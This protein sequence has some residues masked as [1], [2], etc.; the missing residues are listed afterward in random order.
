MLCIYIT[1]IKLGLNRKQAA[2]LIFPSVLQLFTLH[3]QK[4]LKLARRGQEE[5]LS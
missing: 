1:Y 3:L 4:I 2:F 5:K